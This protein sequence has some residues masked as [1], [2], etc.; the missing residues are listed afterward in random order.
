MLLLIWPPICRTFKKKN[1]PREPASAKA[2]DVQLP[3]LTNLSYPISSHPVSSH[4]I[5]DPFLFYSLSLWFFFLAR[6]CLKFALFKLIAY[7]FLS[8]SSTPHN[9]VHVNIHV[10]IHCIHTQLYKQNLW[11]T[12]CFSFVAVPRNRTCSHVNAKNFTQPAAVGSAAT[13]NSF[14]PCFLPCPFF[15]LW[16]R[17]SWASILHV[18]LI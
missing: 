11:T 17:A 18:S 13:F 1:N 15:F 4:L 8:P 5:Q 3:F 14:F 2:T 12:L 7:S 16:Y 10:H 9:D 6:F